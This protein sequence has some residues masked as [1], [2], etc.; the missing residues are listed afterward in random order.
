LPLALI[1]VLMSALA[2]GSSADTQDGGFAVHKWNQPV[3][4]STYLIALAVGDLKSKDLSPRVRVWAEPAVVEAAAYEFAQT[5][6]FLTAA[7]SLTCP[8]R[9]TRY[10]ILCLPPSFPYG[11]MENPCLTF[12]TPT[13]LAGD[14]FVIAILRLSVPLL[15]VCLL[16]LWPM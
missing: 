1:A 5:E 3:P 6:D 2:E 13:V 7:E 16:G 8:Y 15:L 11:G 4:V 14:R 10:D 9:W 12:A